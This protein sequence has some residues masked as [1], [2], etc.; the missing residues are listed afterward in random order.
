MGEEHGLA[1]WPIWELPAGWSAIERLVDGSARWRAMSFSKSLSL[2]KSIFFYTWYCPSSPRSPQEAQ[3]GA[4]LQHLPP[5]CPCRR[6][7]QWPPSLS[8]PWG[9]CWSTWAESAAEVPV[10]QGADPRQT[11]RSS[12]LDAALYNHWE[13]WTGH[14]HLSLSPPLWTKT[15]LPVWLK[16]TCLPVVLNSYYHEFVDKLQTL[17][18]QPESCFRYGLNSLSLGNNI[19]ARWLTPL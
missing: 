14:S 8:A 16:H 9:L 12:C 4:D 6:E 3:K 11:Y 7:E 19:T 2:L 5:N 13:T 18:P 10:R 17:T 1:A 15:F